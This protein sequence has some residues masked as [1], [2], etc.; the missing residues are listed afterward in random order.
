MDQRGDWR[1]WEQEK[2]YGEILY[3]RAIGQLPEM[4]SSKA[5][6]NL[7]AQY[8][9]KDCLILDVGCGAGHYLVSLDKILKVPFKYYGIDVTVN[10]ITLAN[11]AWTHNSIN[12]LRSNTI[13][14]VGD[15]FNLPLP[16]K[17]A[18]IT[19]CN[20][21]LLHLP[22]IEK[23]LQELYRVTKNTLIIRTLIGK[24]SFRIKQINQPE[25]YSID[26]E[27]INYHFFNIYSKDYFL[28][29]LNDLSGINNINFIED[30]MFDAEKITESKETYITDPHD[31]S[32]VLNG[33]QV[34][35]Y[36]IQPWKFVVIEKT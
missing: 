29:L 6:G 17:F 5:V 3:K 25:K 30:N 36:I 31:A 27:P 2:E 4:E 16:D 7:V 13:F 9:G 19:M 26:G 35:N 11:E 34:N 23:P 8:A 14:E 12:P 18:N 10:Y 28:S 33:M 1:I 21:A 22:S 20:N 24:A 15:L 32:T